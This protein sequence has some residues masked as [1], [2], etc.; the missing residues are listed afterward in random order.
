MESQRLLSSKGTVQT[1]DESFEEDWAEESTGSSYYSDSDSTIPDWEPYIDDSSGE[2]LYIDC[3]PFVTHNKDH[4]KLDSKSEPFSKTQLRKSTRGKFLRLIRRKESS[5]RSKKALRPTEEGSEINTQKVKFQDFQEGEQKIVTLEIDSENRYNLSSDKSLAESLLGLI[6]STLSDGNRVMIAGFS[7]D[8]KAKH[9]R[10]IKIGDWLKSINNMD[11]NVQ[12]LDDIL[13]KFINHSEVLL[14]LQRV[15]ATEVTKDPPIN[16]LSVE[17]DF[18]R[19]LLNTNEDDENLSEKLCSHPLGVIFLDTDKCNEANEDI[20]YFY[21]KPLKKNILSICRG[22]FITLN[23]LLQDLTDTKPRTSSILHKGRLAHIV[24]TQF[25]KHLLLYMLP[26]DLASIKEIVLMNRELINFLE[27][28]YGDLERCFTKN[29]NFKRLDWLFFRYFARI[30]NGNKWATTKQF[31]ERIGNPERIFDRT[32]SFFE[33]L[34]P[35]VPT[36]SLHDD[37]LMQIDDALAELEAS[38]Y[39]EWNEDPLDCQ[40]LFTILGSALFHSGYLLASHMIHEDLVEVY[41]FC[42]QQGL[43]HLSRTEP[44]KSLVMWREVFPRSCRRN[45]GNDSLNAP[46]GSRYLLV[47]GSGKDFLATIMEAGGC[48]EPPEENMGPD[49]FYV[50]E[51]QATLAHVQEL[52]LSVV[53]QRCLL[54]NGGYEVAAP[55]PS[56]NKRKNDFIGALN[57]S[58]PTSPMVLRDSPG[59]TKKNEV[60]SILKRRNVEQHLSQEEAYDLYSEESGSQAYSETSDDSGSRR[61]RQKYDSNDEESDLDEFGG[62]SQISGSSF[63]VSEVRQALLSDLGE[64][65]PAQITTGPHNV[66]Y[67]FVHLDLTEGVLIGP[68]ECS[69]LSQTYDVIL[70]N[71]KKCCQNI[72]GIFQNTLRFKNMSAQEIAKSLMNKS[73]IAIKEYGTLFECPF[74]DEKDKKGRVSYW[75]VGRLFYMPH[76]KEVYVC[77]QD[78]VP[79]NVVELAF[80]ISLYNKV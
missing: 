19:E 49:A 58:K 43:V 37:A 39:R 56:P 1:P 3:H 7:Y 68:V 77:Y 25:E 45:C 38:D 76:P 80:K 44:V 52:G 2:L 64:Y 23:H 36:L 6:V 32:D 47:V 50:E 10:N 62:S 16:E 79:Q 33:E 78:S 11:V 22:V 63:D 65:T 67:H 29:C 13:Q 61:T 28:L 40:R 69:T 8:S 12:N 34:M 27:F 21:P 26:D 60:T 73:L 17:S 53:A 30:V 46:D 59:S 57:F 71:F 5:R 70:N 66:L 72:H 41:N 14:T 31:L 24:Y 35:V 42:K 75:V 20:L 51:A 15:A 18:V 4:I 9:E 55:T 54:A 74:L 48:T